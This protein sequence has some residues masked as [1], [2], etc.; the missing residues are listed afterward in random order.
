MSIEGLLTNQRDNTRYNVHP[1][2]SLKSKKQ[3]LSWEIDIAQKLSENNKEEK[4]INKNI[5]MQLNNIVL[6]SCYMP[7]IIKTEESAADCSQNGKTI[8]SYQEQPKMLSV[9]EEQINILFKDQDTKS[10]NR[11]NYTKGIYTSNTPKELDTVFYTYYSPEGIRCIREGERDPENPNEKIGKDTLQ[12]EIKLDS[13]DQYDKIMKFLSRFPQEDNF[14]FATR[15]LFWNDFLEEKIDMDSFFDFYAWTNDGCPDMGKG[16]NGEQI[17]INKERINDSNAEYFNDWTWIKNVW[18]QE[19]MWAEWYAKIDAAS[20]EQKTT[21]IS[22]AVLK[23]SKET[24]YINGYFQLAD[25]TGIINYRGTIFTCDYKSN[26]LKL[27][28]CSNLKNCIQIA[29]AG[30]EILVV[31][32]DNIDELINAIPMFSPVDVASILQAIQKERMMQN[33]LNEAEEKID[34]ELFGRS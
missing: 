19:E 22:Q 25:E 12:W 4:D 20:A 16:E 29:L 6:N 30:G 24:T 34:S 9:S 11:R 15:Q 14:R 26:A 3:E 21:D 18:T 28:D 10:E 17:G 5:P 8:H 27:G 1:S 2:S 7:P 32:K 23:Y 13:R 31:N 33:A